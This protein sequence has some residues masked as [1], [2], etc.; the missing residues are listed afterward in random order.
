VNHY[1]FEGC[2]YYQPQRSDPFL[3]RIEWLDKRDIRTGQLIPQIYNGKAVVVRRDLRQRLKWLARRA[4]IDLAL[5]RW[6]PAVARR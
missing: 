5:H 6:R 3:G 4:G 2:L 1:F